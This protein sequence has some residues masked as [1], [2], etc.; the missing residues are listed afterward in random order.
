MNESDKDEVAF[1]YTRAM[2][3][4]D[5]V[6]IDAMQGDFAGV[7]HQHFPGIHLAM[8]D[9]VFNL[10]RRAVEAGPADYAG[11][12][13]DVLWMS[14]QGLM[15]LLGNGRIFKV[16]LRDTTALQWRELKILFH[17]GDIGEPCA[18]LMLPDED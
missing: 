18:T 16:G 15:R 14:Q 7:S 13:H 6:L 11:V 17:P 1:R 5:G 2:A 8:T 9:S 3:I 12:W 4:A 10:I